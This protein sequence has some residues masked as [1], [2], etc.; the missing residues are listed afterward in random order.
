M[1]LAYLRNRKRFFFRVTWAKGEVNLAEQEKCCGTLNELQR[2][3]LCYSFFELFQSW[4]SVSIALFKHRGNVWAL[5]ILENSARKWIEACVSSSCY[6]PG[7][8]GY[9]QKNWVGVCGPLL[10]TLTLFMTKICNIPYP[11]YDLTKNIIRNP[12]YDPTLTSKSC[13]KRYLHY[14]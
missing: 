13:F 11:S 12:I 8:W 10:R 4:N 2:W 3:V 6:I 5:F 14:N 7:G 9:S 1:V